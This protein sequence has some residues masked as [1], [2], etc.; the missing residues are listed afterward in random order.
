MKILHT[1]DW[2]LGKRLER[3][4]RSEEQ[5]W[6]LEEICEIAEREQVDVILV[7][8]DLYDAFNPPISATDDFYR[9]LKRLSNNGQRLVL[10]IAG[11][12]DA[13]LRIEAPDPLARECGI[14]LV[15]YPWSQPRPF[16]LSSGLELTTTAPGFA[17]F[18]LPNPQHPPL[19]ILLTPYANEVRLRKALDSAEDMGQLLQQQWDQLASE[20][21]DESGVNLLLA[22]LLMMSRG[23]E[24]P[25]EPEDEKSIRIGN[26]DLIFTDFIPTQ[27]QYAALGHLHRFQNMG[28]GPCPVVYSSSILGY[29]FAEAGQAK[30][31][32]LIEAE[33]GKPAQFAPIQLEKGR[34]LQRKRFESV[35]EAVDWLETNPE[36]Y[37]E[38]TIVTDTYLTS[39]DRKRLSDAHPRII[40]PIPHFRNPDLVTGSPAPLADPTRS[41]ESL[42]SDYF[43]AS[44]QQEPNEELI[45]LFREIA[46]KEAQA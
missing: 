21:C 16:K 36:C 43:R 33:P 18:K 35:D 22:H 10:A 23:G 1:A 13:P 41:L 12:H 37:V 32:V 11:N 46:G 38:L 15:G 2:H 28:G 5:A 26:A 30:Q 7:A 9:T 40:G 27:I 44:Q 19:R 31:V 45:A 6:V 39:L 4:D 29:S 25:E 17:E 3:F 24:T 8:G 34:P 42:F 20:Y 14:V